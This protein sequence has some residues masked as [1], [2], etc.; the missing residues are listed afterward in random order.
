MGKVTLTIDGKIC[1]A[2]QGDNI[3]DVARANDIFIPALCYL[4]RCS[5]T[6]ACRLCLVEA[7]GKQVY[8]CNAKAK[9]DMQ[10]VTTTANIVK[11][12]R[13]IMEVY[14]INHPLQCGVCDQSGECELQ[15]NTLFMNVNSQNYAIRPT[16]L[17]TQKWGVMKYDPSLCVMCEKCVTVCKDMV[18]SSALGTVKK[19]SDAISKEHKETMPKD[20]YAV[21]NR[22]NKSLISFEQAKCVDCGEC[23][24]VCP[25]GALVSSDFQ[26]KSNA[27]EL[28]RVPA[29]NP[30]TSDCSLLYYET[31]QTSI[32]DQTDM[33]YRVT[34]DSHYVTLS[35][36]ARYAYNFANK[37]A[38]KNQEEFNSAIEAFKKAKNIKFNSYITNEEALILEKIREKLDIKLVNEDAR[39][40]QEFMKNFTLTSGTSLYNAI[41]RDVHVSNFVICVGSY[42]KTDAPNVKYAFNNAL[43]VKKGVGLYFH[44]LGDTHIENFGKKGKTIETIAYPPLK[45]EAILFLILELF[46]KELPQELKEYLD[47][48]KNKQIKTVVEKV[49]EKIED[50]DVEKEIETEVEYDY[51]KL[52]DFI[53]CK[54]EILETIDTMRNG[55]NTFSLIIGEDLIFHPR[56]ESLAK[57]CGLIQRYT[58]FKVLIIPTQ[59]NTLG[60]SQ[61]CT[62]SKEQ[63]G[64]TVGYNEN[65]DFKLCALGKG[66][67]SM[68]A[69]NQQEGTV[70]SFNKRVVPTNVA[71]PYGG[72]VL[73]DIANKLL[74]RDVEYTIDYTEQLPLDKGF[75]KVEFDSLPN[76]YKNNQENNRGYLLNIFETQ[77]NDEFEK[78]N[79]AYSFSGVIIYKANPINQFNEFS[80]KAYGENGDKTALYMSQ[81]L[82]EKLELKESDEVI[83]Q[84]SSNEVKLKV[85]VDDT[86][87]TDIAYVPY[88][89]K[90]ISTNELFTTS[91]YASAT[92]KKV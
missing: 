6:L 70:I 15:N 84:A 5:P 86:I 71:L 21:W 68:P 35:G 17:P 40:Y 13:A 27:W 67:I 30:Y 49:V 58:P 61:I 60:V 80:N 52:L 56:S 19:E 63:D 26:Y 72:Y 54:Q 36:A 66:D 9:T 59:T 62:L 34:N 82:L 28:K 65:A 79:K 81:S 89:D 44:P 51:L 38:V 2:R 74:E 78:I 18:G 87:I 85:F 41:L 33:I 8:A 3:L 29:I 1:E 47:S 77:P 50:E 4:T 76:E 53:D 83:V 55:K 7:D 22:L 91:R 23:I 39:K 75:K 92:I 57:L 12:R 64:Y 32:S 73:N 25:V 48:L 69:L 45:E 11:E 43:V 31:K 42:L 46:G 20:A 90:S 14:N 37:N 24:S 88:F 16:N 10:V